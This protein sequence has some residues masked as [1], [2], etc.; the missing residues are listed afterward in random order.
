MNNKPNL[1]IAEDD[2]VLRS[3]Y[4]KKFL[5]ENFEVRSAADGEET[6]RMIREKS[7]DLLLLDI[8]MPKM[9]GFQVLK[10]FPKKDRTFKVIMLTNFD[11]SEFKLRALEL[12][13]DDYFVKK[14]MTMRTLVEMVGKLLQL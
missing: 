5:L 3:L 14:N 13:A 2:A 7:P 9:D 4:E 10:E 6:V 11:Q 1:L 12:G 8:H